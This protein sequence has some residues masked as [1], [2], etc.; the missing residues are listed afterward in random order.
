MGVCYI[1]WT[2]DGH[3]FKPQWCWC[4]RSVFDKWCNFMMT[5]S[6]FMYWS[7]YLIT[8]VNRKWDFITWAPF[9]K[10]LAWISSHMPNICGKKLCNYFPT[11]TVEVL[12]WISNSM[13]VSTYPCWEYKLIH[14]S[15]GALVFAAPKER[16]VVGWIQS[17][18][19]ASLLHKGQMKAFWD[20]AQFWTCPQR[21]Y[22]MV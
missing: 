13:D 18:T 5:V 6:A 8:V 21:Q 16:E 19:K 7:L 17:T 11:S 2:R 3:L 15:K 12:E 4:H 22:D 14:I 10:S 1:V 9:T 20:L